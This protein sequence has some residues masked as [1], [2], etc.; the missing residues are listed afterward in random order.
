MGMK[1]LHIV[2]HM[3][4]LQGLVSLLREIF[5]NMCI[6]HI[7]SLCEMGL[8]DFEE[9][10][11]EVEHTSLELLSTLTTTRNCCRKPLDIS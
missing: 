8:V 2:P 1:N 10:P 7:S 6:F 5:P 4:R 3:G 9:C 11:L